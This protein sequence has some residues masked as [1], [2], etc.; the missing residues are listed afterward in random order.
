MSQPFRI[1]PAAPA[2]AYQTYELRRIPGVHTRK[3]TCEEVDCLAYLNGWITKVDLGT[4]LGRRQLEYIKKQS[5]RRYRDV[6]ASAG[7]VEL[8]FEPGQ[9]CFA[10]HQKPVERDPLYI[11]RGGDHRGNPTGLHRQHTRGQ[12][13][14]ED[15]TEHLDKV[16][17]DKQRG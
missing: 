8:M 7:L 15:M 14:V 3:A 1:E 6:T 16:Q 13:W 4:D 2:T 17:Q 12:D 10:Q 9:Q 5:G 11:V